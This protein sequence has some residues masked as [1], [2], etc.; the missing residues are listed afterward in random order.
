[1]C[2]VPAAAGP[3]TGGHPH[4]IVPGDP[5][6]SIVIFRMNSLDPEIKM[7]ELPNRVI[8]ARGVE[9][10]REWISALPMTPCGE[11]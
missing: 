11:P 6:T 9:L 3:G 4:D 1:V 8:D 5:D 10:I 2:K 7:P